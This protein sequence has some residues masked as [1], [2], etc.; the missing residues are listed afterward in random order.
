MKAALLSII[1]LLICLCNVAAQAPATT[2]SPAT[3]QPE[4]K[5]A[6]KTRVATVATSTNEMKVG[7]AAALS[8]PPEKSNPVKMVL[9]EKPPVIDGKLDDEVWKTAPVLKISIK[10][11]PATI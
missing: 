11:N 9:F 3:P 4:N 10:F 5:I 2:A 8:L 1:V 6:T 7:K